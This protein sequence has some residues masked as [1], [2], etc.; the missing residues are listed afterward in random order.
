MKTF[1]EI[2]AQDIIKKHGANLS[3]V[4]IVFPNKRASLFLNEHLARMAGQP[5]WSPVYI[6]ISDLFRKHSDLMIGDPIKLTSDLYHIYIKHTGSSET[7]DRFY[8]WGQLLLGDFDDIDKNMADASKVFANLKDLHELDSVNYLNEEQKSL[9]RRFFG[10]FGP[11][12]E[13]EL[14]KRFLNLWSHLYD[15]YDDYNQLLERQGLA[16]EGSLYRKVATDEAIQFKYD[17][18]LFVGFNMM[19]KV[20]RQL[21]LRLK[22]EGKAHFY[23]D[24]D[25]YYINGHEAGHYINQY[26]S[27]FPNELDN[28]DPVI[29]AN[30][31]KAKDI[32]Y[33]SATTENIQA[34]YVAEWLRE[35]ERYK[36]GKKTAIVLADETLLKSVIH[37]LPPEVEKVNITTGYP[38]T[39][40]PF[41]SLLRLLLQLQLY[42]KGR[43]DGKY[44]LR[45]VERVLRHPY[46]KHIS[47]KCQVVLQELL[48]RKAFYPTRHSLS[49]D[50]GTKLLFRDLENGADSIASYN[51]KLLDYL[52]A[53][54]R[55][56]GSNSREES[57]PLYQE[58]LF[59]CYTML[60]RLLD[61]MRSGDL[62][63]DTATLERLI[64]QLAQSTAI[65]FHGEP[66]EGIQIMGVLE[67]R[68]LD[69][70]HLLVLSCNEGNLP[71]GVNDASFIPYAI[72]KAYG[73]T[74]IDNKVAIYAYY[75]HRMI[76]RCQ[77]ITLTYNIST[78][79]GSKG[80]M[81]QFM[82][83]LMVE[84][85][86]P[87]H[88]NTLT[89]NILPILS[90][91]KS[92]EKTICVKEELDKIKSLSPTAINMYLRCPVSFYF[93]YIKH[94]KEADT[95]GQ[96]EMDNRVFG[97]IFHRSA[98]ELY[99]RFADKDGIRKNEDG[100]ETLLRPIRMEKE[101]LKELLRHPEVF[102]MTVDEAFRQELFHAKREGYQ[103]E[104]D[105]LQLIH[106]AVI[107]QYLKRLITIDCQLAPFHI[108]GLEKHVAGKV[109]ITT[110]KGEKQLTLG[111]DIDRLDCVE[112]TGGKLIRVIDYKTGRPDSA[113]IATV[114]D[115]F[116][117]ETLMGKHPNY[118]LQ[119]MLYAL[120]V[121]NN[122]EHNPDRNPVSPALL[123]IQQ[124]AK[125]DYDPILSIGKK[126]ITDAQD[127][128]EEYMERLKTVIA[129]IFEPSLPFLPTEDSHR[130]DSCPY[131]ALCGI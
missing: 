46:T 89:A 127:Y 59:R 62:D 19:Q 21:C 88:Q 117:R 66:A 97:N 75:F 29:Y 5:L 73:L 55:T 56:I 124:T 17:T 36:G 123:Y 45:E 41:Y 98:Q 95:I 24:F 57:D 131:A 8:G 14:K 23:W 67:T 27:D 81:S 91:P 52:I 12:H 9:L 51:V 53:V 128:Y 71:R 110:S 119:T 61:L 38:I 105:G 78:E 80:Q 1:L 112:T 72:R 10:N 107:L 90:R 47:P 84:S 25:H 20:E 7:L 106:R 13:S 43:C 34:R 130:C 50:E 96:E 99:L 39:A 83:Q 16:Y 11:D 116:T 33:I 115:I 126:P 31:E 82:L 118:Y 42:A 102:E 2:V 32:T 92:I 65:P 114:E 103:P 44:R 58:S 68:G 15:I 113:P 28:G 70:E 35:G 76:Q 6:T 3:K 94:L 40:T 93:R 109:S 26:L 101:M 129:E 100:S 108:L 125:D 79:D 63:V 37:N 22:K 86:H 87:I 120:L 30:M 18:Y 77:D 48:E 121:R 111:G 74:T 4:A 69:F 104:Y 64:I 122:P 85:G 60:N 49:V 54:L